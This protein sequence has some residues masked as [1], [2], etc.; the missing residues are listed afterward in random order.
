MAMYKKMKVYFPIWE[1]SNVR[2]AFAKF[3]ES[4]GY[5]KIIKSVDRSTDKTGSATPDYL[6]IDEN[7]NTLRTEAKYF[8]SDVSE[9]YEDKIDM[10]ICWI[11][12]WAECP[13]RVLSLSEHV[14]DPH[15]FFKSLA[16]DVIKAVKEQDPSVK[17][18]EEKYERWEGSYFVLSKKYDQQEIFVNIK[19]EIPDRVGHYTCESNVPEPLLR[20]L[21]KAWNRVVEDLL[22]PLQMD[23]A[24]TV[25]RTTSIVGALETTKEIIVKKSYMASD[26]MNPEMAVPR[27]S[28]DVK[29][30]FDFFKKVLEYNVC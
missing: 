9:G 29:A 12:D 14:D 8:S 24:F 6:V 2:E 5:P 16:V 27:L 7:G 23:E 21:D 19:Y 13:F 20:K 11:H 25:N 4:L 1:E 28:M 22:K 15:S 30:L 3:H 10:V 18:A 17:V 26:I